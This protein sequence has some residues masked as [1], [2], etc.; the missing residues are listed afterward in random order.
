MGE[1]VGAALLAHAPTIMLPKEV[2]YELNEGKEISLVPGLHRFKAEVMDVLKPDA[3]ILFDSHW[4]TTVEFCV[5]AHERRSGLFTSDE[6]PRGMSQVPYDLKGNPAL[7]RSIA[8][9]ATACGVRT[10]AIDDPFLPIHYPTVNIAH[11]LHADE[12]W[13]TVGCAQTGETPDFLRVGEGVGKAIAESGHRVLLIASGSM[14]HRFWPLSQLHLH[15]ASDPIH[16]SR[17]EAR[18]ADYERLEWFAQGNH[19]AVIE[20]M[21]EFLKHVPEA[22]FGHYLMMAGACGGR[23]WTWPGVRYSDY[24]NA[25]GTSQVHVYFAR[26]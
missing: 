11:H 18:E 21:P 8:E 20:T 15:E 1:I 12:E 22:R 19:A 17:P 10:T 26:P 7:A 14:S 6:L 13:I 16:I 25:T 24:E 2:R 9:H 23:D 5:T 4:F 3:V